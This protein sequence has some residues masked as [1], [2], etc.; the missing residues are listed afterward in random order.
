MLKKHILVNDFDDRLTFNVSISE[1][2][3]TVSY[4][5]F[6]SVVQYIKK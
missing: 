6:V 4:I 1:Y 2:H 3:Y 5:L